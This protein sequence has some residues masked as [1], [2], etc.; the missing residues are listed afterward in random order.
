MLH[1]R[2]YFILS[3]C[4]SILHGETNDERKEFLGYSIHSFIFFLFYLVELRPP[5]IGCVS[6]DGRR[7]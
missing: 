4:I 7:E 6:D 5:E 2:C 3:L 1:I